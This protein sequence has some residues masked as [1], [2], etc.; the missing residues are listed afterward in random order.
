[1]ATWQVIE[2]TGQ[3]LVQLLDQGFK[4]AL[5]LAGIKVQM[6]TTSIFGEL[7]ET[8]VPTVTL[9]LYQV[10]QHAETR[11]AALRRGADGSVRRQPLGLELCY[12]VTP[13]GGRTQEGADVEETATREESRMLG[14][15]LQTL[16]DQAEIT[17]AALYDEPMQPVW[18]PSDSLQIVLESLPLEDHYRIWDA[19][20]LAYRVSLTYRV[21][22]LGLE[23]VEELQAPRVIESEFRAGSRGGA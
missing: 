6:A 9:L 7:A 14:V 5:P 21:R 2:R 22:V 18:G 15:I 20:E 3:T 12:L 10:S 1:V 4:L 17:A 19:S 16:Y 13:W 8:S 11:N 23:P